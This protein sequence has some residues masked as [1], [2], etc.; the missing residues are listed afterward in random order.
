M[1]R[2]ISRGGLPFSSQSRTD[3]RMCVAS[4]SDVALGTRLDQGTNAGLRSFV[5]AEKGHLD[6][7]RIF[8]EIS[9]GAAARE[10]TTVKRETALHV[11]S[12]KGHTAVCALLLENGALH[13]WDEN[14]STPLLL[15]A[16]TGHVRTCEVLLDRGATHEPNLN[17]RTPLS[18]A[19]QNGHA[20][21]CALLLKRGATHDP[22]RRGRTPL[23][24]AAQ[25]D[26]ELTCA[27]LLGGGADVNALNAKGQSPLHVAA[28]NGCERVCR[29][30]IEKGA[31]HEPDG[32]GCTPLYLAA[33]EGRADVCRLLLLNRGGDHRPDHDGFTP[34]MAAAARGAV[35]ICALLLRTGATHEPNSRGV[36][37]LIVAAENGRE[38]V[39]ELLLDHDAEIVNLAN[40]NG[41]TSLFVAAQGG[42]E[43]VCRLLLDRGATQAPRATDGCKPWGIAAAFGRHEVCR[44]LL[45]RGGEDVQPEDARS[46]WFLRCQIPAPICAMLAQRCPRLFWGVPIPKGTSAAYLILAVHTLLP[47]APRRVVLDEMCRCAMS[48]RLEGMTPTV[49]ELAAAFSS[50]PY[51]FFLFSSSG[52][53]EAP[54]SRFTGDQRVAI[55]KGLLIRRMLAVGCG[56]MF[57]PVTPWTWMQTIL[58]AYGIPQAWL[59]TSFWNSP[60]RPC[61][62][63][64]NFLE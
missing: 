29:M 59:E 53:D 57:D 5:A 8:L 10:A 24:L 38:K 27:T 19:A 51:S 20:D 12:R 11:A 64:V 46:D 52:A 63:P 61:V 42:H 35:G 1:T 32:D 15:A 22:D 3:T 13:S 36:T 40:R 30:L 31:T 44:L 55:E 56:G 60:S 23:H 17:E 14:R 39:C 49:L 2:V 50:H 45:N 37:P 7:C 54:P 16:R 33:F 48:S 58:A 26:D 6:V 41:A 47:D 21:V 25:D 34:L 43:K 4:C 18:A 28:M 62:G 9:G